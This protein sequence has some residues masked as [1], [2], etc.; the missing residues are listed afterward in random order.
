VASPYDRASFDVPRIVEMMT[1]HRLGEGETYTGLANKYEGFHEL[2]TLV[3]NGRA[4][5]FARSAQSVARLERAGAPL[6]AAPER[7]TFRRYVF[8]VTVADSN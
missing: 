8:P 4:L 6:A 2:S 1:A 3:Q 7:H 5:L